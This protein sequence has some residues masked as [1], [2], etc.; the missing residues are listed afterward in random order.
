MRDGF[1]KAAAATPKITVADPAANAAEILSIGYPQWADAQVGVGLANG[2]YKLT[3]AVSDD[4]PEATLVSVGE[5][6]VVVTNAGEYVFVLEKGPSYDFAV[7][8]PSGNVTISAVDDIAATRGSPIR[9]VGNGTWTPDGGG[10]WTDYA[11]NMGHARLWWLPWLCG[12]P[13]VTH[14]DA[15]AGAVEF[16]ANLVDYRREQPMLHWTASDGLTVA[17]PNL[18]TT[19]VSADGAVAWA[20]A[21]MTVTGITLPFS[22]KI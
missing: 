14:I 5:L 18:Q 19:Q 22:S 17:S 21:S 13:D 3:V 9:S 8:P 7:F 2:L 1:I 4:L 11:P 20:R 6:S 10:F 16:H 12:S 15:N